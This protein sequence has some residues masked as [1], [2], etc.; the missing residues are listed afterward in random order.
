VSDTK[1]VLVF[2]WGNPDRGDDALGPQLTGILEQKQLRNVELQTDFQLQI[3]HCLDLQ[4]RQQ[5]YLVDASL[6]SDEPFRVSRVKAGR[7]SSFTSHALSPAALVAACQASSLE[8][9][10]CIDLL[11]IRGYSFEL[12]KPMSKKAEHNLDMALQWLLE[13]PDLY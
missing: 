8:P 1:P 7:D 10:A 6:D 11:E 2:S 9:T 12:G 4:N 13:R 5:V 3:E